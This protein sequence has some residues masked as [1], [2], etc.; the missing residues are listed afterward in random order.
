MA[1]AIANGWQRHGN[2]IH[3]PL[4]AASIWQW[5]KH[6][7]GNGKPMH[8]NSYSMKDGKEENDQTRYLL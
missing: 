7:F 4:A 5:R 1:E 3:T 2:A 6:R 8:S